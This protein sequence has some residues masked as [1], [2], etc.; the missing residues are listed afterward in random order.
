[1]ASEDRL[2]LFYLAKAYEIKVPMKASE[3]QQSKDDL[4][5]IFSAR[6]SQPCF[7]WG[8]KHTSPTVNVPYDR[9]TTSFG[10]VASS[11]EWIVVRAK[12][13]EIVKRGVLK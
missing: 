6:L 4:R 12:T 5:V 13:L 7:F 3:A 11:V 10:L 1:M 2:G 8:T 9:T